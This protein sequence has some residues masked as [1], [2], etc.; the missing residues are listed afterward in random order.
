MT[1]GDLLGSEEEETSEHV[2]C[3]CDL[4]SVKELVTAESLENHNVGMPHSRAL[5]ES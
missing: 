2:K 3:S 5:I 1:P 4:S